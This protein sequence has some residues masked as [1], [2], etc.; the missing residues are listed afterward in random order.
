[1]CEVWQTSNLR[2]LRLGEEKK[3]EERKIEI[4]GQKCNG[5]TITKLEYLSCTYA[6]HMTLYAVISTH[7]HHVI[8][9][10]KAWWFVFTLS[11]S[12]QLCYRSQCLHVIGNR[13]WTLSK[14]PIYTK[15]L[16]QWLTVFINITHTQPTTYLHNCTLTLFF[17]E[18]LHYFC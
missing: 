13:N 3:K 10:Q 12:V 16:I 4:T 2:P 15:N 6:S 7:Y 8:N 5:P 9:I 11:R 18:Y 17:L 1:M 14:V